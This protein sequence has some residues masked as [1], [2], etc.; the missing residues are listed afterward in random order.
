M[1]H[2][3]FEYPVYRLAT[4]HMY[5]KKLEVGYCVT[6]AWLISLLYIQTLFTL[7][8]LGFKYLQLRSVKKAKINTLH[9]TDKLL[10]GNGEFLNNRKRFCCYL[11]LFQNNCFSF[12]CYT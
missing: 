6:A 3:L 8:V 10:T 12:H 5:Y 11:R 2:R 4:K 9:A 1:E 7:N